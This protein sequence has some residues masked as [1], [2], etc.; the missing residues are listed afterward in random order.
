MKRADAMRHL[1]RN[2]CVLLREGA[3]H[4][5]F[6]SRARNKA[7]AVPRRLEPNEFL[8]K[9]NCRDLEVPEA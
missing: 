8:G 4:S 7:S 1:E 2:G 9:K 6:V 3:K 5:V